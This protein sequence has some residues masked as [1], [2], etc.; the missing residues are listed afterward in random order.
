MT[1]KLIENRKKINFD[2]EKENN[3]TI[4]SVS[5]QSLNSDDSSK[6][7]TPVKMDQ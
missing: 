7:S 5:S 1:V 6:L 4:Y 3:S 2:D